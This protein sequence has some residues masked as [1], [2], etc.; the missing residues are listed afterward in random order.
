M[1]CPPGFYYDLPVSQ[2]KITPTPSVVFSSK[3]QY[4]G[5]GST[6]VYGQFYSQITMDGKLLVG[7]KDATNAFISKWFVNGSLDYARAIGRVFVDDMHLNVQ[8]ST[9]TL[10]VRIQSLTSPAQFFNV[11]GTIA[12]NISATENAVSHEVL[13][14]YD[15]ITGEFERAELIMTS[16][17]AMA[18]TSI[19]R[20]DPV[21]EVIYVGGNFAGNASFG[22]YQTTML[23]TDDKT[24]GFI[25][26]LNDT[27]LEVLWIKQ[28]GSDSFSDNCNDA[29]FVP[30]SRDI[31]VSFIVSSNVTI[32]NVTIERTSDQAN[33]LLIRF[34]SNGTMIWYKASYQ[35]NGANSYTPMF[36]RTTDSQ[37][38]GFFLASTFSGT[39]SFDGVAFTGTPGVVFFY[40]DFNGV[41]QW[42]KQISSVVFSV[43]YFATYENDLLM[44]GGGFMN[45]LVFE[46]FTIPLGST[47]YITAFIAQYNLTSNKPMALISMGSTTTGGLSTNGAAVI[48]KKLHVIIQI[49]GPSAPRIGSKTYAIVSNSFA[50]AIFGTVACSGC[51]AGTFSTNPYSYR[52]CTNCASGYYSNA[53]ATSCISC[54]PGYA[55]PIAGSTSC[56]PCTNGTYAPFERASSC[57]NC[58]QGTY[59]GI[60]ATSC[61]ACPAGTWSA[62]IAATSAVVCNSCP[63]GTYSAVSGA[64]AASTCSQC[65]PGTYSDVPARSSCKH[66]EPGTYSPFGGATSNSTCFKCMN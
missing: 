61:T 34:S 3:M 48:N 52:G 8:S 62:V 49:N 28:I 9:L 14:Q 5:T 47:S 15:S 50:Y 39:M 17:N 13:V 19:I 60:G 31:I 27:T 45:N 40:F 1:S 65:L 12:K 43:M 30:S 56:A 57:T 46:N 33:Y 63:I 51:D 2:I 54:S 26:A 18:L 36:A 53:N 21:A 42:G 41:A 66:C 23:M 10:A 25:C 29:I 38:K 7:T 32:D 55:A 59:S 20:F 64:M 11:D 58:Q 22:I 35:T 16:T 44:V 24:D 6:F 37:V 4:D